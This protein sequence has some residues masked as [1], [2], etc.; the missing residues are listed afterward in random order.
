MHIKRESPTELLLVDGSIWLAFPFY[1]LGIA[2]IATFL[3]GFDPVGLL[4]GTLFFF[5]AALFTRHTEFG[6]DREQRLARWRRRTF[7]SV[8]GG[9]IPFDAIRDIAIEPRRGSRGGTSYRLSV[10]TDED[11]TPMANSVGGGDIEKYQQ[12]RQRILKFVG[13]RSGINADASAES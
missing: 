10:I 6:F 13:H 12:L 8:N 1:L 4:C 3:K 5:M 2:L 9:S 7:L 11:P